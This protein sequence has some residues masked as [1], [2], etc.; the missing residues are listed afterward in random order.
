MIVTDVGGLRETIGERGTGIVCSESTPE[1]IAAEIGRF[2]DTP[3]LRE[4]CIASI[5][6]VN[7]RLSWNRFCKDLLGF[8]A[9]LKAESDTR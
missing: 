7:E 3:M 4:N 6:R 5:R 9:S 2:F 1:C 8:A